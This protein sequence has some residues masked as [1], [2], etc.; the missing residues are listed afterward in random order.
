MATNKLTETETVIKRI[1]PYLQRRGYDIDQ[2]M[3]FETAAKLPERYSKGYVD[4]LIVKGETPQFLVEAKRQ[5]KRLSV[6]D[7]NQALSYGRSLEVPFVVVTN[8]SELQNYN[9]KT[10]QP[11]KW[12]GSVQERIPTKIQ[13]GAVLRILKTNPGLSEIQLEGEN[14]LPFRPGLPLKQLNKLFQRCHNIIRNIEKDEDHVFADFSKLLFLKLLEEKEDIEDGFMLPY[15][16]KFAELAD[17][18]AHRADQVKNAILSMLTSVKGENF[19][20]VVIDEL[21]LHQPK[22]YHTL[23]KILSTVSFADSGLDTKGAAFE[24]FV[25]ATL[26]GKRL[27]QYFTP[28]PL[29]ELMMHLVGEDIIVSSLLSGSKVKVLDPACGTGGFLVYALKSCLT[30]IDLLEK[31]RKITKDAAD[32]LREQVKANVFFGSDANEGVASSAKMNMIVAGDGHT[33]IRQEDSLKVSAKNWSFTQADTD[34]I[35]TNP[36][37]GTTE[38]DSLTTDDWGNYPIKTS[39]GQYLFLERMVLATKPGAQICTVIDDGLLN[40]GTGTALRKWLLQHTRLKAVVQLPDTTFQ[41]NKINVRSSVLLL[42]K[43]SSPDFDLADKYLISFT[44]L[45]TLGYDG[46]GEILRG[47]DTESFVKKVSSSAL[48]REGAETKSEDWSTFCIPSTDITTDDTCRFDYKYWD[49][50]AIALVED[51]VKNNAVSIKDLNLIPTLRG[52][53]PK[54]ELYVDEK[55]GYAVVIKAGS[56]VT[57]R[58]EVSLEG[59]D[60]IEKDVY[61]STAA[62]T[63][64]VKGDILVSSTG[65]GTLGKVAVFDLDHPA[66]ADGHVAIVRVD[67]TK[68][69]PYYLCDYLRAGKGQSQIQ[70]LFTGSTGLVELTPDDLDRVLVDVLSNDTELQ[71]FQSKQLRDAEKEYQETTMKARELLATA[72][73]RF[74]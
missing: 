23:V 46:T 15:S 59:A 50:T 11:I 64:L 3:S 48:Q 74:R 26:K 2:D 1:L 36:P 9:T 27:G 31:N 29:V 32:R 70:R 18:P 69:N 54:S 33:N 55:D 24:Y 43:R 47:F 25:R 30:Q 38:T 21:H 51:L 73:E 65:E 60:W 66:I 17:Y 14:Q 22:T 71:I 49:R 39:K 4:I 68:I 8:G 40:T 6:S 67:Q 37:F 63:Y 10:G 57:K 13:L 12:N 28:R 16:Y 5:A 62:E 34:I 45:G 35:L 44:R 52:K 58:G 61:D 41:P 20:A 53:S 7:K 72:E 19:G 56:N 42:E